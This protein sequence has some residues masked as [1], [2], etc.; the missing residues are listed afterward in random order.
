MENTVTCA[1]CNDV[2]DIITIPAVVALNLQVEQLKRQLDQ[3]AR[4]CELIIRERD[5]LKT[6]NLDLYRKLTKSVGKSPAE[7]PEETNMELGAPKFDVLNPCALVFGNHHLRNVEK[8]KG[9]NYHSSLGGFNVIGLYRTGKEMTFKNAAQR[10][11]EYLE[12]YVHQRVHVFLALG[13]KEVM[14]CVTKKEEPQVVSSKILDELETFSTIDRVNSVSCL[15][16]PETREFPELTEINKLLRD[17]EAT[18]GKSIRFL[19][20][21]FFSDGSESIQRAEGETPLVIYAAEQYAQL[22]SS[23]K[24][25]IYR[26]LG[27]E[28]AQ[29]KE[30]ELC[31]RKLAAIKEKKAND[32]GAKGSKASSTHDNKR[33][34]MTKSRAPESKTKS[35]GVSK[36]TRPRVKAPGRGSTTNTDSE[37]SRGVN[38][39]VG[40]SWS[41]YTAPTGGHSMPPSMPFFGMFPGMPWGPSLPTFAPQDPKTFPPGPSTSGG[42]RPRKPSK[43]KKRRK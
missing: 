39:P 38:N 15:L 30:I 41:N 32:G 3:A 24:I 14:N 1:K 6:E 5:N 29:S 17:P 36:K 34:D 4:T 35:S 12:K 33:K 2:R 43:G 8:I 18:R 7:E 31:R 10:C 23:F 27:V 19:D 13:D 42:S 21:T 40:P 25:D 11:K 37:Y 26:T 28:A 9:V 16:L 22:A 20:Y